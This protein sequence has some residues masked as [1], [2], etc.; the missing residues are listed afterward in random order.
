MKTKDK[1]KENANFLFFIVRSAQNFNHP[2]T[3]VND[4]IIKQ[5]KLQKL[6]W[7]ITYTFQLQKLNIYAKRANA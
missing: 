2:E 1:M 3:P 5:K 7:D 6:D 4:V